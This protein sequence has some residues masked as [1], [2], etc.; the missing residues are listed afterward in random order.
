MRGW[1]AFLHDTDWSDCMRPLNDLLDDLEGRVRGGG[2]TDA[3]SALCEDL[4]D[5]RASTPPGEWTGS[6]ISACRQHPIHA[7]F[8]QDPYTARAFQKPRGYA[9]DAEMLDY[10]Y[11]RTPPADTTVIGQAVFRGTTGLP[12]G[13]SVVARR[14]LLARRIDEIAT[15]RPGARVLSIACGHLREAQ[16]SAAVADKH[17]AEFVA[18]DQDGASL[19]RVRRELSTAGVSVVQGSVTD[20]IRRRVAFSDFDLVYAAGLFDY[21]TDALSRRLLELM[22]GMLRPGGR[23]LVANFTPDNHGRGYMECFMDWFL[24]C[25]DDGQMSALLQGIEPGQV[26]SQKV[27]RDIFSNMVY[28]EL[29]RA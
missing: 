27:Y 6:V 22:V 29:E 15:A 16:V 21:L 4:R 20:I 7:L 25:R 10:V 3:V 13:R 23:L 26:A 28:L 24:T 17:I 18:F 12:N 9:G 11:T 14:D 19:E 8:L 1:D 2:G 5:R